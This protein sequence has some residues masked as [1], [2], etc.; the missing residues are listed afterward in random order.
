MNSFFEMINKIAKFNIGFI[1]VYK[2]DVMMIKPKSVIS[3]VRM[4]SSGGSTVH[5]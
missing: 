5:V 2:Q 4:A 1:S 3:A